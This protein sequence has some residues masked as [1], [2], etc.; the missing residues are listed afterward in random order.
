MEYTELIENVKKWS[1]DKG[2]DK[3]EPKKQMLKLMEEYGELCA[4]VNK[5]DKELIVDSIGDMAVVM[6]ILAQQS[7]YDDF[8]ISITGDGT[9]YGLAD[10]LL[11]M[12]FML[13]DLARSIDIFGNSRKTLTDLACVQVVLH[14][15]A[16]SQG[17]TVKDCL[18]SA[19]YE[20]ADRKG[21]MVNGVFVK[22][23]DL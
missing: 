21:E 11:C 7:E 20:I 4:G 5:N 22:E 12:A 3:A 19:W 17:L 2:L 10:I 9:D 23:A 15:F 1:I 6:I 14:D 13:G 16:N 18:E 8:D